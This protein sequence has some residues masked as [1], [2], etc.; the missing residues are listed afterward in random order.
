M[1][2]RKFLL[3][4]PELKGF[5]RVL[6]YRLMTIPQNFF[7]NFI[8]FHNYKTT[9]AT[10]EMIQTEKEKCH[11]YDERKSPSGTTLSV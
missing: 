4:R 1:C 9:L 3:G 7:L 10:G 5:R 6:H 8:V 11:V 2:E